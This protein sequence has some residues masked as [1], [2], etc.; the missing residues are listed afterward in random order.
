M[1]YKTIKEVVTTEINIKKSRFISLLIPQNQLQSVK[2]AL[3]DARQK[4]PGANHYC[5]AYIIKQDAA[6]LERCSDDGEP[7]KTAGW[8]MLN[9]LKMKSLENVMAIVIR[10]FGG[11]LLG[12]GGLVK[13]YT[14]SVQTALDAAKI[15]N[16]EYC[17]KIGITLDYAYYGNYEKQFSNIMNQVTDI[18]FTD[19][20]KVELW[21]AVDM[22][23]DFLAKADNLSLGTAT[24]ELCEKEFIPLPER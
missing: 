20:I 8:P 19:R 11:T 18:Q 21:I 24:T 6:L 5:Y 15:V 14:Q 4:Y 3:R 2:K 22:A 23:D 12:T 1:F 17:Q 16:M 10:Y 9:V 13:A 7:S